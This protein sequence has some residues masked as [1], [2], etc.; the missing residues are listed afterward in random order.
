VL[1]KLFVQEPAT[2]GEIM[3]NAFKPAHSFLPE[4]AILMIVAL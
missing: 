1:N 4:T 3:E 2:A